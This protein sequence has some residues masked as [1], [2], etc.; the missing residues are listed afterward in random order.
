MWVCCR[1][2]ANGENYNLPPHYLTRS[3][4]I[5][6]YPCFPII[7]TESFGCKGGQP[8]SCENKSLQPPSNIGL[9]GFVEPASL[10]LFR[11]QDNS[12]SSAVS[13]MTTARESPQ[14]DSE[15][16]LGTYKSIP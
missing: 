11:A 4:V 14:K 9:Q 8:N 15:V 13:V 12:T 1:E 10:G 16:A 7:P 6:V 3:S 5:P 2:N